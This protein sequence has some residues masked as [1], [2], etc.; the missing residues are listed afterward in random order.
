MGLLNNQPQSSDK[1]S[2]VVAT[3]FGWCAV[4]PGPK[5]KQHKKVEVNDQEI[6]LK[7]FILRDIVLWFMP[8]LGT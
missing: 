2:T 6:Y 4:R 5:L 7:S 8:L 3:E 1:L